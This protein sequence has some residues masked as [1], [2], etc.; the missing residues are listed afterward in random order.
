MKSICSLTYKKMHIFSDTFLFPCPATSATYPFRYS[1]I[2]AAPGSCQHSHAPIPGL[3]YA[4]ALSILVTNIIIIT[5]DIIKYDHLLCLSLDYELL[6]SK[7]H[8]FIHS[9]NNF[10][11]FFRVQCLLW[12]LRS[13]IWNDHW[14]RG[15]YNHGI[16]CITNHRY[17]F[18]FIFTML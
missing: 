15:M 17:T 2:L 1:K 8:Q 14:D 11:F 7:G 12:I 18:I 16:V 10:F 4:T 6:R 3:E 5:S 9:F 13:K